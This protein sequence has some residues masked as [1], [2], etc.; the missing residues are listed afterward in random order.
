MET[1]KFIYYK[2]GD[3]VRL[4]RGRPGLSHAGGKLSKSWRRTSGI[5]LLTS[6]TTLY[7]MFTGLGSCASHETD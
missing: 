7:H 1:K 3:V 6:V 5:F 4:S 2:D